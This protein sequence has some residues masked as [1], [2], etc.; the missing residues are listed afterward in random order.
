MSLTSTD[1]EAID[2]MDESRRPG[3]NVGFLAYRLHQA[4]REALEAKLGP[5]GIS[6]AEW[7]VLNHCRHGV[8][9]PAGLAEC[10]GVDR[11]AI[12]R[13]VDRLVACALL[14]RTPNPADGRSTLIRLTVSGQC[15]AH[16]A[17]DLCAEVER[18]HTSGL[19][20]D[21]RARLVEL[22][23]KV[24]ATLPSRYPGQGRCD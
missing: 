2:A 21:E 19:D 12:T 17:A 7:G 23:R 13:Q 15:L 6:P 9:T 16:R 5:I 20:A 10:L 22:L 1:P 8:E 11:A 18:L 14:E 4:M 24:V 3:D